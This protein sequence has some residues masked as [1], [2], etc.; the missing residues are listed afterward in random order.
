MKKS[1]LFASLAALSLSLLACGDSSS[2]S[3]SLYEESAFLGAWTCTTTVMEKIPLSMRLHLAQDHSLKLDASYTF[4]LPTTGTAA[5]SWAL[6]EDTLR[7]YPVY[8]DSLVALKAVMG[9]TLK[10]PVLSLDSARWTSLFQVPGQTA[11][12]LEFTRAAD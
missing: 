9:D 12:P 4:L 1:L 5:G 11:V 2:D 10:L 8:P 6:L 7:L 3:D